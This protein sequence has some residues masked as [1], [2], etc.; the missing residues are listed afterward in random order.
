MNEALDFNDV[1]TIVLGGGGVR[2]L[3]YFGVFRTLHDKAQFDFF[4]ARRRIRRVVGVSVGALFGLVVACGLDTVQ[5]LASI[6]AE[7]D[8]MPS[9][10]INPLLLLKHFGLT[11]GSA[12]RNLATKVMQRRGVPSTASFAELKRLTGVDLC[13]FTCN[14]S[15]CTLTR[16]SAADTPDASVLEVVLTSC[17]LPPF[18]APVPRDGDLHVDGGLLCNLPALQADVPDDGRA[19]LVRV[20]TDRSSD[21]SSIQGYASQLAS[22][23]ISNVGDRDWQQLPEGLRAR[24]VTVDCGDIN[25]VFRFTL[26]PAARDRLTLCGIE[27]A[28]MFLTKTSFVPFT[29]TREFGTQTDEMGAE[30][31]GKKI[32]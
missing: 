13:V 1:D 14:L 3:A 28:E 15:R 6:R 16:F 22:V 30:T 2:G 11:R 32:M 9:F 27:A 26:S 25:D 12:L 23:A 31:K 17:A 7:V 24:T 19:L 20:T 10:V 29:A 4:S 18:F 8:A 21:I 5:D